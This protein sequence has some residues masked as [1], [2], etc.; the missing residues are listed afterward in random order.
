MEQ[1]KINLRQVDTSRLKS[2]SWLETGS[3]V[4]SEISITN[5]YL[6]L[7]NWRVYMLSR[8][9]QMEHLDVWVDGYITGP[10]LLLKVALSTIKRTNK[11]NHRNLPIRH[12]LSFFSFFLAYIFI[13]QQ[14]HWLHNI[15]CVLVDSMLLVQYDFNFH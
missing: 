15:S 7:T 11:H 13:V 1:D 2:M 12:N 8:W 10:Q 6:S 4:I 5:R 14:I 3:N 9:P